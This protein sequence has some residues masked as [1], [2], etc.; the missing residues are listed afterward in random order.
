M[1]KYLVTI[2]ETVTLPGRKKP[3]TFE[4]YS[5]VWASSLAGA[6]AGVNRSISGGRTR[7]KIKSIELDETDTRK[8]KARR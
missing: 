6:R 7:G 2:V 1:K 4:R 3:A 8:K 5:F